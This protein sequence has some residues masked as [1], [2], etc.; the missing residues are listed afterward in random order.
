[1]TRSLPLFVCLALSPLA[2]SST[3]SAQM[4][5]D[6]SAVT[7]YRDLK[8]LL[9]SKC[10]N[11]H[12]D[13]GIAP[14]ALTSLDAVVSHKA[15]I[16]VAVM[17]RVMPPW[18]AGKGCSD[19]QYDRSL[20]DDQINL[21]TSW[22][23]KGAIAGNQADYVAP[24]APTETGGLSRV[25]LN[26]KMPVA[27]TP[28]ITPDD[29]RCFIVDWPETTTKFVS[30]FRANPG[31]QTIVHHVIAFLATPT[32]VAMYQKLDDADP[33]PGYTC[34]G[35]PGGGSG[36]QWI[37]SWAPGSGG[38]D[39]PPQTGIKILPGSKVILQVHYNTSVVA[40]QPDL[41]S[42]DFKLDDTVVKEAVQLPWTNYQWVT[43]K[44]MPIAAGDPDVMHNFTYDPTTVLSIASN[45]VLQND[46]PITIYGA[47]I[48]MHTR[49]THGRIDLL[50]ANGDKECML[51]VP[52]WD[53]H[54]QG[55]YTFTSQKTFN[56]GDKVYLECHWNNAAGTTELN[57]GEGTG[58]E[59]CLSGF[60]VTQ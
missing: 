49:G 13:G 5:S 34:F 6:P 59:M 8:P 20:S 18:L 12:S 2:C 44:K 37:G 23:D 24:A 58:D 4:T 14:F 7:Y 48:H 21:V 25:D 15:E 29:Y 51:D 47:G 9:E 56:P 40:P 38:S 33:A 35:G 17:N 50:R 22:V 11:C 28:Q 43:Q 53:F 3:P 42:L 16:R 52:R 10:V 31:T 45:G 39:F 32:N 30:G 57:W 26:L 36:G 19:Y 27:Y 41:T 55:G 54:W 1:M 60:Y 46:L